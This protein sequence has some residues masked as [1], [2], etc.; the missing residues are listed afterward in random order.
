MPVASIVNTSDGSSK[1]AV[2]GMYQLRVIFI[3][4]SSVNSKDIAVTCFDFVA[5]VAITTVS[6]EI[7][8]YLAKSKAGKNLLK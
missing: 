3:L 4:Y 7:A 5:R 1:F 6:L 8:I 2:T